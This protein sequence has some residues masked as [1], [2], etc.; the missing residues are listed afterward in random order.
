MFHA[1]TRHVVYLVA[2]KNTV[3]TMNLKQKKRCRDDEVKNEK[4]RCR[5]DERLP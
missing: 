5:I 3:A 2:L 1:S 4:L